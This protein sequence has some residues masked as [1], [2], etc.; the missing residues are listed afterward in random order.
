MT[1]PARARSGQPKLLGSPLSTLNQAMRLHVLSRGGHHVAARDH[2]ALRQLIR[3]SILWMM[4]ACLVYYS[5]LVVGSTTVLPS[6]F[7]DQWDDV[8][9]IF[10]AVVVASVGRSL[11]S[12]GLMAL[13]LTGERRV[14]LRTRTL[15]AGSTLA[16]S[17]AGAAL[18]GYVGAAWGLA[19][20]NATMAPVWL[21]A[22][23]GSLR[24]QQ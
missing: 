20:A 1:L 23:R 3:S 16:L 9:R 17:V 7:G 15:D 6:V 10:G 12:S 24:R 19:I 21:L 14:L 2:Q 11:A 13:Q 8:W 18:Y 22:A 4:A 5:I